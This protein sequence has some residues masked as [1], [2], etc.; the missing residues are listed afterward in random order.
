MLKFIVNVFVKRTT[1]DHY[2]LE[3]TFS[4][5]ESGILDM[6]P[7]LDFGIFHR[8]KDSQSFE[9][10]SV[11]FDTIEWESGADLDPEFVYE[12]CKKNWPNNILKV[13]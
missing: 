5:G 9:K 11:A 7:Y 6:K 8:L 2:L 4:N 13:L 1:R 12:K 3:I 10:V